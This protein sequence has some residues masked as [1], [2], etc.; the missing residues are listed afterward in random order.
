MHQYYWY[1]LNKQKEGVSR[2]VALHLADCHLSC[3]E[4]VQGT[5]CDA[6]SISSK[7][8]MREI[9]YCRDKPYRERCEPSGSRNLEDE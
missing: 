4:K 7:F 8:E 5:C 9:P 2:W 3:Y 6:S 1:I